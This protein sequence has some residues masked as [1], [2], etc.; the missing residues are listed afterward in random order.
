MVYKL[1]FTGTFETGKTTLLKRFFNDNQIE[2]V[3]ETARD[4]LVDNPHLELLPGFQDILF[5]EQVKREKLAEK[6][7]KPIIICDRGTLDII[8][9]SEVLG[10]KVKPQWKDSIKGRYDFVFYFSTID[11]P[12][13]LQQYNLDINIIDYRKAVD[14][15]IREVI[16]RYCLPFMEVHGTDKWRE[17]LI[18]IQLKVFGYKECLS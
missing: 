4:L 1:L 6:K 11:I 8:A 15:K 10:H 13:P 9:F 5:A 7:K 18:R 12:V 17:Q 2:I 14:K 3:P 16:N